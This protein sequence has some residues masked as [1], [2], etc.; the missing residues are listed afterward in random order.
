MDLTFQAQLPDHW[1]WETPGGLRISQ[2]RRTAKVQ[3]TFPLEVGMVHFP[4]YSS[5]SRE[6][7]MSDVMA[8][9]AMVA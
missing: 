7:V 9:M 8:A 4:E 2:D 3:A 1:T 5:V 6:V